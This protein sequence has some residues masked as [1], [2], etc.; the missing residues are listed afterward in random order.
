MV[1]QDNKEKQEVVSSPP[2][3]MQVVW[4][5]FKKDKVAMFS[6]VAL[7]IT[8]VSIFIAAYFFIDQEE[9]MKISLRGKFAPPGADY[10]LGADVG[11][12]DVFGQLI[13]GAKNS[14]LIAI[15]VTVITGAFG[16]FVG[17]VCGYFGG[18]IDNLFMRIIDFFITIP[19]TMLIIVVITVIP[20]YNAWAFIAIVSVFLWTGTARLVR[21]KS[22]SESRRDYVNASKTLG[23]ND[24]VILL[25]EVMP[26]ISSILIVELTLNFAGNIGIE[27]GLTFLGYGLPPETPSLGML[28]SNSR[29]PLVIEN[30]WWAWLPAALLILFL[31]L[32]INYVGQA[33]RR[34]ADARQR[35]G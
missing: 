11:G 8:I 4:R 26:N 35:L 34:S 20:K 22:L 32:C 10:W 17:L 33:L 12:R 29:S 6:L 31:M 24:F 21:S 28:V 2:T 15:V 23:T 30:Y 7:V 14:L 19:S 5:E 9:A 27:T 25:K 1:Q 18:W 16:I 13:I 3:G